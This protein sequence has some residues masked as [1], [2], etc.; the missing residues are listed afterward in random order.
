MKRTIS[1]SYAIGG[2]DTCFVNVN[3]HIATNEEH[4]T[5]IQCSI[6]EA[7]PA[8]VTTWLRVKKFEARARLLKGSYNMLYN[9]SDY[10]HGLDTSLFIEAATAQIM[11][12]E[13]MRKA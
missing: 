4:I 7:P 11:K 12:Q 10:I 5:C 1:I 13:E 9:D 8:I 2:A 3:Y 6:D